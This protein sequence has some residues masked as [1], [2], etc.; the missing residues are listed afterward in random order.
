MC[1][2][3]IASAQ[4]GCRNPEGIEGLFNWFETNG[5]NEAVADY[6]C[7][8][9]LDTF[10][11]KYL[12]DE[13]MEFS[14]PNTTHS[15]HADFKLYC[16]FEGED[17]S[18]EELPSVHTFKIAPGESDAVAGCI[19]E[20]WGQ[21]GPHYIWQGVFNSKTEFHDELKISGWL[22]KGDDI[23]EVDIEKLWCK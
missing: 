2:K 5:L 22:F 4:T 16:V 21:A 18:A 9:H 23:P 10:A 7:V 8:I 14:D 6:E 1:I 3:A 15:E 19:V 20:I 17:Q 13:D 12:N 11:S